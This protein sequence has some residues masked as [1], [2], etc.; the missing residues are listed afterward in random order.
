MIVIITHIKI[1]KLMAKN[2][3]ILLDG[4]I[5]DRVSIKLP[6]DKRDEAFEYLAFEQIL[7]DEDLSHEEIETGSIDGRQDA[8]IDGFFIVVNGH[9]LQ[10][11]ESFVWPRAG[12]ELQVFIITCKHH[13]TFRQSPL[14]NLAASLAELM[15]FGIDDSNLKGAYSEEVI[16]HRNNLKYA[17]RK[18]SPRLNK[19]VIN[20]YYAS[21][22]DTTEIGDEVRSRADHIKTIV[23][24]SFNTCIS[25]FQFIG[26]TEL[27]E[28]HRR[29]KNYSLELSFI[30]ALSRGERYVLLA[31]LSDY[32]K[33]ISDQGKLRRYLFESNVRDFMGMNSVNEDI[34][35][36]LA[37]DTPTDFWWLNNGVTMLATSASVVGKSIQIQDI[38]IVN[39]LQTT[40]SIYRHFESGGKDLE[41]RSV[42][43]K[44]IVS[45][46]ESVR[47]AIIRA[48]NNQTSV[49][50]ASLHATDK[51]QRDIED[52][53][54]RNGLFY[55]RRK[56]YYVN[57]GHSPKD[58]VTPLYIA[59][60]YVGLVLKDL[61]NAPVLRSKFMRSPDAYEEVFSEK[62]P[63]EVWPQIA[64]ILKKTDAV[65]EELRPRGSGTERFLKNWRYIVSFSAI[66]L[67]LGKLDFSSEDLVSFDT[68]SLTNKKI[69][70]MWYWLN[71]NFESKPK[72]G[73]WVSRSNVLALCK[74][75][76]LDYKVTGLRAFEA[77][78]SG[79]SILTEDFI[80]KVKALLPPQ[81]WKP[82]IHKS[83]CDKLKCNNS[84][85]SAAVD[86][87]VEDGYFYHQKDG[88]LYDREG[89][90]F[91]YD[92]D[93]VDPETMQLHPTQN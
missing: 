4:I 18:L 68:N 34:K 49:E 73:K 65:L 40:E 63:I 52:V 70:D 66:S 14:D 31:K 33:F 93:R 35:N 58:I 25:N 32:Y 80:N 36:T 55:E 45:T 47:D 74:K 28:M 3:R 24:E 43:V 16:K 13:D 39:G 72:S 71:T 5:D 2:D 90:V 79:Q 10:D 1:T 60:G 67:L 69:E 19:F 50:Y 53:L 21:R 78:L 11:P 62:A 26:S 75:L 77:N 22:G 6:S 92:K 89:N 56:N 20:V 61:H 38:Q 76:E 37:S 51:I 83:I 44:V 64:T 91:S 88:I 86:A 12:S 46:D 29:I 7:K 8:G 84:M 42:L 23:H 15:D 9:P 17:Y 59:A 41:D 27:V 54:F 48:T 82:G 85:Y 30:E 87:L 57:L 81:P